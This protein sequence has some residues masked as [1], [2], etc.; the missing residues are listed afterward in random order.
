MVQ[1]EIH[2][3]QGQ[4]A[5]QTLAADVLA[6]LTQNTLLLLVGELGA[7]KTTFTQGLAR[8]VGIA[9]EIASP[10]FTIVSEYAVAGH[11]VFIKLVHVDLYRLEEDKAPADAMVQE[12]ILQS[13]DPGVLTVIEWADRLGNIS[14]PNAWRLKF[15]HGDSTQERIVEVEPPLEA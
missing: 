12:I 10:T 15:S 6:R 7:G 9:R 5:M 4:A 14:V 2:H 11:P 8:S 3:V 13:Q 1:P